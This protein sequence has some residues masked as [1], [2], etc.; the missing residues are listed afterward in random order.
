MTAQRYWE[1]VKVGDELP[2]FTMKLNWTKMAEQVSGSQDFY[3]VHHDPEFA[4]AGGHE[5]IFYN[6]GFTRASLGRL[7]TDWAGDEGWLRKL[8]FAMRRMNRN[9]DTISV[10]GRVTDKREVPGADNEVDIE[11]WIE[12]DHEGV[13]TPASAVVTLP[14][15][16]R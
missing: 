8:R 5:G 12:N 4:R 1:E 15:R 14:S 16:G 11:L 2:G 7:V 13:T 10:K 9:G 6:T 3:P